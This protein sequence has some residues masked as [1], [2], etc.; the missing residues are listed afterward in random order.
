M[1]YEPVI[2]LE[3]HAQMLTKTKLFC[4]CPTT[5]GEDP[6]ANTCPIC[7]GFPG[8]LPKLNRTAVEF[9]VRTGLALGCTINTK[10]VFSRKN[11]FYPDL[12][13]G[14]QISQYDQPLCSNGKL[15]IRVLGDDGRVAYEKDVRI[16]RIHVEEDAGKSLHEASRDV[17][18][19]L[20]DLNR[21]CTP[22][23]EIVSEPD[24]RTAREASAYLKELRQVLLYLGVCDG[25]MEEGSMRCDANVSLRP[26]GQEKFGTRTET[27][28]V[29]SFRFLERA[30]EYE[31]KRQEIVLSGGGTVVQETRLF[32]ANTGET[33]S[34]R[35]KEEAH[36]YRYFPEPDLLPLVVSEAQIGDI[37]SKLPELPEAK[38]ERFMKDYGL[39]DYDAGI[40]ASEKLLSDYFEKTAKL[41]GDAKAAAN[42]IQ[43][44]ILREVKDVETE[45][46]K[47]KVTPETLGE[48]ISLIRKGTISGK[49]AKE[50]FADMWSSGKPPE[51]IVKAKGLVQVSDEGA[52]AKII[53]DVLAKSASQVEQY[54][55][56]KQ[57]VFGFFVGAVMKATQGKANP[58]VVNKLLK[59]RLGG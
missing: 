21:A 25:N 37:R 44:E 22:L 4:G 16:T 52:L 46:P 19:S 27:K 14:Y 49:I 32:D 45:L 12:P 51:E 36:D 40:L 24:I 23:M 26:K 50:V 15:R 29:N 1:E 34:M 56:G 17:R 28:N 8:V 11:Y 31:M 41:A 39:S 35:S 54:K 30:I 7:L 53:D 5:F 43:T 3:V 13:K 55:A 47:A 38:R 9:A 33:R 10:S 48:L 58:A 42:W 20:I 6:N 18:S 2:G 59:E 57:S